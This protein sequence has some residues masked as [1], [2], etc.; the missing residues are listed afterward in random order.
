MQFAP[1][2]HTKTVIQKH[3]GGKQALLKFQTSLPPDTHITHNP[4]TPVTDPT[5]PKHPYTAPNRS[6]PSPKAPYTPKRAREKDAHEL[7]SPTPLSK[8]PGP[9]TFTTP[10]QHSPTTTEIFRAGGRRKQPRRTHASLAHTNITHQTHTHTKP[11]DHPT[12]KRT[13]RHNYTL[14][15]HKPT[16]PTKTSMHFNNLQ[17]HPTQLNLATPPPSK[18]HKPRPQ[19]LESPPKLPRRPIPNACCIDLI[20]SDPDRDSLKRDVSY[21]SLVPPNTSWNKLNAHMIGVHNH[22]GAAVSPTLLS[23]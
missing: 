5:N 3:P 13:P 7:A 4:P 11:N 15:A 2:P 12:Y 20:E 17:T 23:A 10:P 21:T 18:K 1:T 8:Y 14:P 19:P 16:S 22:T 9:N 6:S